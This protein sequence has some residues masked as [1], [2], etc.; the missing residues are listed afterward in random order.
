MPNPAVSFVYSRRHVSPARAVSGRGYETAG[1]V[2]NPRDTRRGYRD[3]YGCRL[4]APRHGRQRLPGRH[5][6]TLGTLPRH[7]GTRGT[8]LIGHPRRHP[9]HRCP[10]PNPATCDPRP[11]RNH[12]RKLRACSHTCS[13]HRKCML[14]HPNK[15]GHPMVRR[16]QTNSAPALNLKAGTFQLKTSKPANETSFI[17]P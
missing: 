3:G 17:C 11:Y 5:R 4:C 9:R 1:P 10:C 13:T 8:R 6:A 7:R 2:N 12:V 15:L 16:G 14:G